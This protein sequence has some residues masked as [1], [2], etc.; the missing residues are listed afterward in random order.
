MSYYALVRKRLQTQLAM[1][2]MLASTSIASAQ[3]KPIC[4]PEVKEQI[5]K[6]LAQDPAQKDPFS[7]EAAALQQKIYEK[8]QYCIPTEDKP[9]ENPPGSLGDPTSGDGFCGIGFGFGSTYYERMPCCGYHPQKKEF[10]CSIE[11]LEPFGFGSF[12]PVPNGSFENVRICVDLDNN[13]VFEEVAH[14]SVHL[15]NEIWGKSP[16]WYFA[17]FADVRLRAYEK[18]ASLPLDGRTLRARSLLAW[19][20]APAGCNDQKPPIWGNALEYQIRLDP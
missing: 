15:G 2:A 13:G 9:N 18:L 7:K 17:A 5:A 19:N 6:M 3:D 12:G 20:T 1:T 4:G 14:G 11:I 8:Y 10:A 16:P